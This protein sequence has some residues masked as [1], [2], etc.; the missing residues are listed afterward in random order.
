MQKNSHRTEEG[1]ISSETRINDRI[2]V[3][4]VRLVGPNGEQVGIVRIEDALRLA[5]EADLDLVEVAP[6][7]RPPVCK[8]MDYGKFKY[9]SAQKARESRR[10]Q[11]QTVIKEQKL[12]PKIDPHDYETKKGHVSR[13]L[14]QGHKVKVTIMFRGR[15]QSRPELGFRLLQRLADDVSE[16]GFIEANPKQDGRNMIMVLA[17]HKTNKTKPKAN[18]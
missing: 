10:N 7:A 15:E 11:Q 18:A 3:P 1:P 5:Q 6:Q 8:L 14:N 4:E 16:L 13:F 17:P 12:R 9:E 2:R